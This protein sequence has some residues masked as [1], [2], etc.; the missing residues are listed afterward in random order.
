MWVMTPFLMCWIRGAWTLANEL[1]AKVRFLKPMRAK[2]STTM[3]T[4]WSPLRKWWWKEMV[5]PSRKPLRSMASSRLGRIL[6]WLCIRST[7]VS[8]RVFTPGS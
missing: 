2:V 1:A 6:L 5:M 3:F 7:K 8:V 4:T